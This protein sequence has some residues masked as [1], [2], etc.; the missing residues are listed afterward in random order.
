MSIQ[1]DSGAKEGEKRKKT[2]PGL[3]FLHLVE[4]QRKI[5]LSALFKVFYFACN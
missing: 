3:P 5:S 4:R 1:F 2:S